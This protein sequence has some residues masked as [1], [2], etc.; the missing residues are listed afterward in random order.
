MLVDAVEIKACLEAAFPEARVEVA[1]GDGVHFSAR[2]VTPN[3]AGAS[4]L[5]R[6]REVYRA[7]GDHVGRE[8][9]AL[10]LETLTPEEAEHSR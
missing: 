9:H 6:H 2:I 4:R 5:T 10:A 1:S 3:F 7:L 8:I